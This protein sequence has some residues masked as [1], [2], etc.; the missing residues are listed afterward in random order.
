MKFTLLKYYFGSIVEFELE[1]S[2]KGYEKIQFGIYQQ[3]KIMVVWAS[4]VVVVV[5]SM[6]VTEVK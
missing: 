5:S 3:M 1:E 4:L 6:V 2:L